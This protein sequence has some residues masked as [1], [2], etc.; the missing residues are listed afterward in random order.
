MEIIF[1]GRNMKEIFHKYECEF[2]QTRKYTSA[3]KK[4]K[5]EQKKTSE[6]MMSIII[7]SKS[8]LNLN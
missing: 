6:F 3:K 8:N 1:E 2:G 4:K 5:R 7:M